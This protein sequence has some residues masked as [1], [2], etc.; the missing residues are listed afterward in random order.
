MQPDSAD[1]IASAGKKKKKKKSILSRDICLWLPGHLSAE[2]M[3]VALLNINAGVAKMHRPAAGIYLNPIQQ[4]RSPSRSPS[5]PEGE[6]EHSTSGS[7]RGVKG[8]YQRRSGWR[9]M[10]DDER[11]AP[12]Q[13]S[14]NPHPPTHPPLL[15]CLS[16]RRSFLFLLPRANAEN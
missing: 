3:R 7:F 4:V 12:G 10:G 2:E 1:V 6:E 11:R 8:L 16:L 5:A 13:T 14:P 15:F 9:W